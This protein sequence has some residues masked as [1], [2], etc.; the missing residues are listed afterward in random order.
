MRHMSQQTARYVI[1]SS[2]LKVR[3]IAEWL[4]NWSKRDLI[5]RLHNVSIYLARTIK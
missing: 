2:K 5:I 1:T 4:F 3:K